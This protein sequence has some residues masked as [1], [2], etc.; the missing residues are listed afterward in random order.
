MISF[1]LM[2]GF[3]DFF[4]GVCYGLRLMTKF[5]SPDIPFTLMRT[6]LTIQ[7]NIV[8]IINKNRLGGFIDIK[9]NYSRVSF[10]WH[11]AY[12][13]SI[14]CLSNVLWLQ[15]MDTFCTI[16]LL[17]HTWS[18]QDQKQEYQQLWATSYKK[19]IL[20]YPGWHFMFT[21]KLEGLGD[22]V[23]WGAIIWNVEIGVAV[24]RRGKMVRQLAISVTLWTSTRHCGI[25]RHHIRITASLHQQEEINLLQS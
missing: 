18:Q 14:D 17:L 2:W 7:G 9:R 15:G 1:I 21:G 12:I 11:I 24:I 10:R 23:C 20:S 3:Y 25:W 5:E 13:I 22:A 8:E 6:K 19:Q 4:T 16:L